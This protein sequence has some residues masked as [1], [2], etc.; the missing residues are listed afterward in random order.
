MAATSVLVIED[1]PTLVHAIERNLNVIGYEVQTAA[2]VEEAV[3]L[4]RRQLP[5]LLL[6]DISLPDG[7][8]W[9]V[10]R[11]LRSRS[12]LELPV[13]VMSV[14]SLDAQV[15]ADQQVS[16]VLQKPFPMES[17]LQLVTQ[18]VVHPR[19]ASSPS[20]VRWLTVR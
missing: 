3:T 15:V 1:D 13:I 12:W 10:L 11:E 17:L 19:V 7:C 14:L 9:D 16:A 18:F 6:L 2:T 5:S 20:M 8:G 4:L